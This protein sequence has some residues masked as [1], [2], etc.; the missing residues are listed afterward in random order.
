MT[1]PG[2]HR[3]F[4][5]SLM[6]LNHGLRTPNEGINLSKKSEN[7][8]RRGRQN[9]LWRYLKIWEWEWIFGRSVKAISSPGVRSPWI[10]PF[11][12]MAI[13]QQFL[14][15]IS[16]STIFFFANWGSND[17]FELL[18]FA[19]L[20]LNW[21]ISYDVKRKF[22]GFCFFLAIFGHFDL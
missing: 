8:G 1:S 20:N 6:Q 18:N 12:D 19:E 4:Y 10:K 15:I 13:W 17:Q 14:V 16:L 21:I 9:M 22:F 3:F 11:F 2:S 5:R 7:L